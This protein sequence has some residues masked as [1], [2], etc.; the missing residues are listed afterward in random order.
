[1]GYFDMTRGELIDYIFELEDYTEYLEDKIEWLEYEKSR[2][3]EKEYEQNR[4][5][6]ADIF[7]DIVESI[8]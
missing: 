1:M 6:I 7:T 2:K 5:L 3:I 8:K 4:C